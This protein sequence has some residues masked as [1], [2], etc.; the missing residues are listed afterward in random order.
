M[1]PRSVDETPTGE[2]IKRALD[3]ARELVR[4][5][6]GL[7]KEEAREQLAS[8]K[9]AVIAGAVAFVAALLFLATATMAVVLALGGGALIALGI[10]GIYLVVAGVAGA[11]AYRLVPRK[12]VEETRRRIEGEIKELKEH[13]A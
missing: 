1:D 3:D 12:P 5:E 10:S 9:R 11:V 13:V 8:A 4:I 2:L 6:V 7:A